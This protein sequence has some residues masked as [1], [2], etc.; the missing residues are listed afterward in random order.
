MPT[1]IENLSQ[2]RLLLGE[3]DD[4]SPKE[5]VIYQSFYNQ[6]QHH[7]A[8]LNNT[9]AS[10]GVQK[11]TLTLQPGTEDYLIAAADF[12]KAFWCYTLNPT[13]Q[14]NWRREIP[15]YQLMNLDMAYQGPQQS[16]FSGVPSDAVALAFY[17]IQ[18]T[19]WVRVVPMPAGVN[20]IEIWYETVLPDS[21][22]GGDTYGLTP[23][24]H[25]IRVQTG[26]SVLPHCNWGNIR[27]DNDNAK[28]WQLKQQVLQSALLRDEAKFQ[29]E[30]VRYIGTLT[31]SG[32]VGRDAFGN[33]GYWDT[34]GYR[35]GGY[36]W[37]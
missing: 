35:T 24:H 28:A 18:E 12:G 8:Q 30:F 32:I 5:H 11:F 2:I 17:R 4:D 22:S 15:F 20:Y 27:I 16:S 26:L 23:F 1:N 9:Q 14:Y 19:N 6:M 33:D 36:G 29:T 25:L 7:V 10:W 3:P 13:D 34:M 31:E 37:P 21:V